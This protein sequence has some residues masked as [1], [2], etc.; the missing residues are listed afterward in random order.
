VPAGSTITAGQGTPSI[1]VTFGN[2]SGAITVTASNGCGASP[3]SSVSATL[4]SIPQALLAIASPTTLC[5]G[6]TL[7]LSGA[8]T[9]ATSWSWTGPG[10]FSSTAQ[11]PAIS[12]ISTSGAG[13]YSLNASNFCGTSP[14]VTTAS[15]T[16]NSIPTISGTTP[17]SRNGQ[18]TVTLG[19]VASSGTINW[20]A[21]ATGGS[22]LGTGTSFTTPSLCSTTTYYVDATD[23]SCTTTSRTPV[24]ATV[25][26]VFLVDNGC[27]L[28]S[29]LVAYYKFNDATD[30][31]SGGNNGTATNV[32]FGSS[33]GKVGSGSTYN[34]STSYIQLGDAPFNFTG[35]F[36]VA[37]WYYLPSGFNDASY[38]L[39]RTTHIS[40][41]VSYN[42]YTSS[43]DNG[44]V[45]QMNNTTSAGTF[46]VNPSGLATNQ[47]YFIA[48]TV[49]GTTMSLYINNSAASTT[50]FSG[51]RISNSIQTSV[52]ARGTDHIAPINGNVDELGFWSRT[53]TAQEVSDLYN[54]GIGQTMQ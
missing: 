9:G 48:A 29:G 45:F 19:A 31:S 33:Y 10:S 3:A 42:I 21:A 50:T 8:A 30:Y 53:L 16:V 12:S 39:S 32:T 11:N 25:N 38:I 17:G 24:I 54:G 1:T 44:F 15:V 37:F 49:S 4:T 51:T 7:N 20:Y 52:G 34:G 47:W 22:S 23:N 41:Y 40:P 14:T 43:G 27:T 18:G 46:L 35:D 26:K 36:S 13:V 2:T 6:N 28:T 5:A